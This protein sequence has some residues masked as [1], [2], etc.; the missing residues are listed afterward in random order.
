[1][2]GARR[3]F[4]TASCLFLRGHALI[5]A[6]VPPFRPATFAEGDPAAHLALAEGPEAVGRALADVLQAGLAAWP[7]PLPP[8]DAANALRAAEAAVA[9]LA[10]AAGATKAQ[11]RA[12]T[13]C[14]F[15][16][17]R[18]E[19]MVQLQPTR[20]LRGFMAFDGLPFALAASLQDPLATGQAM[21]DAIGL[22]RGPAGLQ[23][24]LPPIG[25]ADLLQLGPAML[26]APRWPALSDDN[27]TGATLAEIW[28]ADQGPEALDVALSRALAASRNGPAE[29][30]PSGPADQRAARDALARAAGR[31]KAE[32]AK[33]IVWT[34]AEGSGTGV[35]FG[36]SAATRSNVAGS[37]PIWSRLKGTADGTRAEA[38]LQRM[39]GR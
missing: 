2:T 13:G 31:P 38:L 15:A 11:A 19:G 9:G 16:T 5:S 22:C 33:A 29:A 30:Q 25:A 34:L 7:A 8:H 24:A 12:Q 23:D 14:V 39:E 32:G 10:K 26:V 3:P 4:A 27:L 36:R 35:W 37:M 28:H 21:V 17:T 20:A 18:G 6:P 1:M